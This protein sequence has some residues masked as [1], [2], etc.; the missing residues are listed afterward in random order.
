MEDR[1]VPRGLKG[2]LTSP[3]SLPDGTRV[4]SHIEV[5]PGRWLLS[6]NARESLRKGAIR[7]RGQRATLHG[8]RGAGAERRPWGG[9]A[10]PLSWRR[11]GAFL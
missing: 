5:Q 8:V 7:V 3:G 4:L 6:T 10:R 9:A 2:R 1:L 11:V